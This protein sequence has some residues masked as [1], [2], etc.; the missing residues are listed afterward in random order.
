MPVLIIN[1]DK[2]LQVDEGNAEMLQRA[3]PKAQLVVLKDMNHAEL[4]TSC[5]A[6]AAGRVML[7]NPN[8]F[9]H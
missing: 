2:D 6:V 7:G 4:I 1:G 8:F 5:E 3:S 9:F